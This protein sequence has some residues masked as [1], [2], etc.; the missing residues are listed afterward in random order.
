MGKATP[1]DLEQCSHILRTW[2]EIGRRLEE[3]RVVPSWDAVKR[4][5]DASKAL[6][7]LLG[8]EFKELVRQ[9]DN[10]LHPLNDPFN[11]D[12]SEHRSFMGTREER[13]SDW[14][15][16]ILEHLTAKPFRDS[17]PE[18]LFELMKIKNAADLASRC[19]GVCPQIKREEFL[20]AGHEGQTGRGDLS[21]RYEVS[22]VL[23]FIEV[24]VRK[25][26]EADEDL[27]KNKGYI[28]YI[29]GQ[30]DGYDHYPILLVVDAE[31]GK[32]HEFSVL[33]WHDVSLA[34]RQFVVTG[35]LRDQPL[36]GGMMLTFAGTI[37]QTL[38]GFPSVK[39]AFLNSRTIEIF[40]NY[41]RVEGA[42]SKMEQQKARNE[43]IKEGLESYFQAQLAVQAFEQEIVNQTKAVLERRKD[44]LSK[45][46]GVTLTNDAIKDFLYPSTVTDDR[47]VGAQISVGQGAKQLKMSLYLYFERDKDPHV[48]AQMT[49]S[50]SSPG[51]S[52]VKACEDLKLP[53]Q[54]VGHKSRGND[55]W[56]H[57]RIT[58]ENSESLEEKAD[59]LIGTWIKVWKR[60]GGLRKL[61]SG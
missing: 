12:F 47:Y 32:Y 52:I 38:L 51:S 21:I 17:H 2:A 4:L 13:Y 23:I 25:V 56:L 15:A 55:V 59:Q 31:E 19:R 49:V 14:L 22:R 60:I 7:E 18:W 39:S 40:H 37:E 48:I 58:Q 20:E 50:G 16:W 36:L 41:L 9:S 28:E 24:K 5:V 43:L 6:L 33:R 53:G 42:M 11:L 27:A 1:T 44:E 54:E 45:E 46:V 10:R 35:S 34:L 8:Q 57:S 26:A 61:P 30:F 3:Q 29:K